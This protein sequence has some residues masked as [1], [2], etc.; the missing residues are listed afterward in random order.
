MNANFVLSIFCITLALGIISLGCQIY[1][2]GQL[3]KA[4]EKVSLPIGRRSWLTPFVLGWQY[5]KQLEIVDVMVF[6]SF[7][8]GLTFIGILVTVFAVV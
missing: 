1:V 6:W 8:L 5:A 7:I 2:S 3:K 4:G